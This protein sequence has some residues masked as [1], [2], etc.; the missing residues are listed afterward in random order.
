MLLGDALEHHAA[1]NPFGEALI[2]GERRLTWKDL[3]EGA[4]RAAATFLRLGAVHGDRV[5]LL[6]NNSIEFVEAYYGLSKIGCISAPVMPTLVGSEIAFIANTLRARIAL[7]EAP[8][9]DLWRTAAAD[10]PSIESVIGTGI[11]HDLA[12]DWNALTATAPGE[13]PSVPVSPQDDLTVKFTSGT[14]GTPKGCVRTHH[15]FIMSALSALIE[16]P[17]RED[18]VGLV[19]Q[20]LAAGMAISFL[21]IYIFRGIPTVMLPRFD[22]G[23]YLDAVERERVSHATAMDWMMRRISAHPT[24]PGRDL[25][26]IRTLHGINQLGSLPPLLAQGTFRG[27]LTA[28]YAS[29]EA[30]GLVSFKTPADFR[31]VLSD[32]DFA[33]G[34]SSGRP[35]RLYRVEC[36]DDQLQPLPAGEVGELAIRGPSVFRGYWERPEETAKTLRGGWLLTGDL[37]EKDKDG[38]IHLRGR[39][40][41]VIRTG[42]MNVYPAEIEPLLLTYPGITEAAVIGVPDP[43]WGERVVACV[44]ASQPTTADDVMAYCRQKL[45][46]HKRP[47]NVEFFD[48]FPLT[49]SGKVIKRELIQLLGSKVFS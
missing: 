38:Y 35:G 30:G 12:Y 43:E 45:A 41:D 5:V 40:R 19:A 8:A 24:F 15:N 31:R 48:R 34:Y 42:G 11:G 13:N 28:G 27:G 2:F 26:S 17:I 10:V 18:D 20:P 4:N 3:N 25:S 7:V 16:M 49:G 39:K 22:A 14:T 33:G 21:T 46:P 23:Q 47:K 32:P 36:L 37:A 44:I 6:M 1:V 29:S 9:A